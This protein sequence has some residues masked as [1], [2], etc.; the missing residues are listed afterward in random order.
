MII[1]IP[2]IITATASKFIGE[3]KVESIE[4]YEDAAEKLW[5]ETNYKTIT[6]NSTND[7]DVTESFLDVIS[8]KDFEFYSKLKDET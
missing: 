4:E 2:V 5:S 8:Q 1:K 3:V 6:T 7:F